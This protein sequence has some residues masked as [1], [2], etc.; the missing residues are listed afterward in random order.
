MCLKSRESAFPNISSIFVTFH[1]FNGGLLKKTPIPV[2]LK[3]LLYDEFRATHHGEQ[4]VYSSNA[5]R[6][7]CWFVVKADP[8]PD[9]SVGEPLSKVKTAGARRW[10]L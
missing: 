7:I 5:W 2:M 3:K 8:Y 10:G 6:N 1:Y 4:K 9:K